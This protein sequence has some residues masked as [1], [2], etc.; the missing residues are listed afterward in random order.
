MGIGDSVI[1]WSI[2]VE[3]AGALTANLDPTLAVI[4]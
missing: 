2:S 4:S 1:L 3:G